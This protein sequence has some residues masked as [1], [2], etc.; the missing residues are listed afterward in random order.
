[1]NGE[2]I[3]AISTA[4]GNSGIGIVRISGGEAFEI[5]DRMYRRR[6]NGKVL[7]KC[8]SHTIQY[9]Y[10]YDGEELI[11]EVLV[12]LMRGPRSLRRRIPL[13]SIAMA[14]PTP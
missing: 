13:R 4:V 8:E 14:A 1:M 3:A 2:T 9:G 6:G 12:M 11:D 5:A 10:I 7:S